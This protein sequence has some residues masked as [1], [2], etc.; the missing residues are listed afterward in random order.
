MKATDLINKGKK[1]MAIII[2]M[3]FIKRLMAAAL[4][5]VDVPP[6]AAKKV[7]KAM[8]RLPPITMPT[9]SLK[10]ISPLPQKA[11]TMPIAIETDWV[12]KVIRAPKKTALIL[13]ANT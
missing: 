6:I 11:M 8:P 12:A 9:A 4:L 7:M 5:A 1:T 10:E 3:K 13:Q 2:A